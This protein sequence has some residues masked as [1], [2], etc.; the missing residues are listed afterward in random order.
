MSD[1]QFAFL[2]LHAYNDVLKCPIR[3]YVHDLDSLA[4]LFKFLETIRP[5]MLPGRHFPFTC[6][7]DTFESI[8]GIES[9]EERDFYNL[10]NKYSV[11]YSLG[12]IYK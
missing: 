3:A 12:V 6:S 5:C 8:N 11:W 4:S 7:S 10:K 9:K 2:S 1:Y